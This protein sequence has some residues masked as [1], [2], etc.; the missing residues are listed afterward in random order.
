MH[1]KVPKGP[2][3]VGIVA[4]ACLLLGVMMPSS[5]AYAAS[6]LSNP[7]PTAS[8]VSPR[9]DHPRLLIDAAKVES[10]KQRIATPALSREYNA[11]ITHATALLQAP[12]LQYAKEDGVRILP[13]SQELTTRAQTLGLAFQLTGDTRYADR[14]WRNLEAVLGFPDW[15]PD[16]FLDTA[17][18]AQGVALGYD[19]IWSFLTPARRDAV[20]AG[21]IR[22]ALNPALSVYRSPPGSNGPYKEG[23]NWSR[24]PNNW[25][26]VSNAGLI[27][28]SLSIEPGNAT[29]QTILAYALDSVQVGLSTYSPDGGY[30][31]GPLYWEYS[32]R[33]LAIA[34]NSLETATGSDQ[35][36]AAT[37][38]ITKTGF[39]GSHLTGPSGHVFSFGDSDDVPVR[40]A[41][42]L[43]LATHLGS[44]QLA[45]AAKKLSPG[46]WPALNLI[47]TAL[48]PTSATPIAPI[49]LD[50]RYESS[51]IVTMRGSWSDGRASFVGFRSSA[52]ANDHRQLDAGT[53]VLDALGENWARDLGRDSYGLAGYF[54]YR[55]ARWDYFRN[56]P[57]GHNTL[58]FA[59]LQVDPNASTPTADVTSTPGEVRAIADLSGLYPGTGLNWR[60]GV[61][62]CD[63]RTRIVIQDE[64]S[65][66]QPTDLAWNMNTPAAIELSEDQRSAILRIGS[67]RL[68]VRLLS[69]SAAALTDTPLAPLPT[70]PSPAQ[71]S[72]DGNRLSVALT[73]VSSTVI[74]LEFTPLDVPAP[75]PLDVRPLVDWKA[76]SAPLLKSLSVG[77]SELS[78]FQPGVPTYR[79]AAD[80]SAGVPVVTATAEAG[81]VSVEPAA[82]VPGVSIVAVRLDDGSVGRYKVIFERGPTV[83]SSARASRTTAGSPQYTIDDNPTTLW[84]TWDTN[85]IEWTLQKQTSIRSM[86]L[87]WRANSSKLSKYSIEVSS[88]RS[89]WVEVYSGAF[90]GP[91]GQQTIAVPQTS[92]RYVRLTGNG[93]GTK[94]LWTALAEVRIFSYDVRQGTPPASASTRL[95]SVALTAVP[96]SLTLGGNATPIVT[97]R[98]VSGA[99]SLG[100]SLRWVSSRPDVVSVSPDGALLAAKEGVSRVGVIAT[101][102]GISKYSSSF[103]IRVTDPTKVRLAP[104]ADT[105]VQGGASSSSNYGSTGSILVK[106]SS[107]PAYARTGFI[108]FDISQFR[109]DQIVS[110]Q[111]WL[112]GEVTEAPAQSVR[113]DAHSAS[114]GWSES[115]LTQSSAPLL[116][117]VIG[118]AIFTKDYGTRG[119]ELTKYFQSQT[120]GTGAVSIALSQ[121][122]AP[123]LVTRLDSKEGTASPYLQLVVRRGPLEIS[124]AT[125]SWTSSG[126]PSASYDKNTSTS[127]ATWQEN[128][129]TWTLSNM[130]A[131]QSARIL[132]AANSRQ[133]TAFKVLASADGSR[134]ISVKED[135]YRG[136]SGWQDLVFTTSPHS[137][138]VRVVGRGDPAD[139]WTSIR[140]IELFNYDVTAP[141]P[142]PLATVLSKMTIAAPPPVNIGRSIE[143]QLTLTD[144]TG[145]PI[146]PSTAQLTFA[147][148]NTSVASV[149]GAGNV[150]GAAAGST[151]VQVTAE[152]N[153]VTIQQ[154][155]PVAV[156]DPERAVLLPTADSYV[157]GGSNA[158][159]NYGSSTSLLVKG[160]ADPAYAR[161]S[162]LGFDPSALIGGDIIS[163]LLCMRGLVTETP[164]SSVSLDVQTVEGLWS[165]SAVT[166]NSRP[167]AGATL[168]SAVF[169]STQTERCVDVTSYLSARR[170]SGQP[171]SFAVT[172]T[173][174]PTLVTK[175]GS[176]ESSDRPYLN[177]TMKP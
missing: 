35:G 78:D 169:G 109:A 27:A 11:L 99:N 117:A 105:F 103:E 48:A 7:L 114:S 142:E 38:G 104:V 75:A 36:L 96:T 83:I 135:S 116:G 131:V 17:E 51:G 24:L 128:S 56:R 23:G 80:P 2:S 150:V 161:I 88:D 164:G 143:L 69:P 43:G 118:S 122:S 61:C 12:Y 41:G 157:Q 95:A 176:R 57:E 63:A 82:T 31:E 85:W 106:G 151:S 22:L 81:T 73:N 54:D 177:V 168:G 139:P 170:S 34:I 64:V 5:S 98:T 25:N 101:A 18:M 70:S 123:Y 102:S 155:V 91:S 49:P 60:R 33:Y 10:I 59:A 130:D 26:L 172:Q 29:A 84:T 174:S 45:A 121:N 129:I 147:S 16:H 79:V 62:L 154:S 92:A 6:S 66:P 65:L 77:G 171:A 93:D 76:E 1:S 90:T 32:T 74:S 14:L 8:T 127:W 20:E 47:W 160:S 40:S 13:V 167:S 133:N 175:I 165:E 58:S 68:L 132:W 156:V 126:S 119:I 159:T 158:D 146:D 173:S 72:N 125:A 111:L 94:D 112:A 9:P 39:F 55:V 19:W 30:A 97:M 152:L 100:A 141:A 15:N 113:I 46:G 3:I 37:S 124:G 120:P 140:E 163:G 108:T 145:L 107:D 87:D 136:P 153:G 138:F 110:A 137:K 148:M 134:W 4:V 67:E 44:A 89:N 52:T 71:S 86:Q 115:G 166:Y 144:S 21:I 50:G 149:D 42:A 162:Y 28:A 53:F